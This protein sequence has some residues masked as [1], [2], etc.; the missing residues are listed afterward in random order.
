MRYITVSLLV[1][2]VAL[3]FLGCSSSKQTLPSASNC[4]IPAWY[5]KIPEDPNFLFSAKTS[6]SKDMQLALDKAATDARAEIA[7]QVDVRVMGYWKK[8]DEETNANQDSQLS[9]AF[10]SAKELVVSTSLS[11]SKVKE[12]MPCQDGE[13]WRGYS[14][15]EYSVGAADQSLL[16]KIKENEQMQVKF[17]ATQ[18]YKELEEK[19]QQY[20]DWKKSTE[21]K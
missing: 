14:L 3:G 20:E 12:Q 10:T 5:L 11:G 1:L 7:S 21:G 6:T 15:V 2:I 9:Q 13:I 16:K 8:F 17:H 4:D 19:V 18:A